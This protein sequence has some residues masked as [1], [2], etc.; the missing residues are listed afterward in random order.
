MKVVPEP[1]HELRRKLSEYPDA[2]LR[3]SSK[4]NAHWG[5]Y[6]LTC[7]NDKPS[8]ED[9]RK[10]FNSSYVT[11]YPELKGGKNENVSTLL[12]FFAVDFRRIYRIP[13]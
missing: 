3:Y 12:F 5:N 4:F 6:F 2:V 13:L 11:K 7:T 1:T 10:F 8:K 9:Y